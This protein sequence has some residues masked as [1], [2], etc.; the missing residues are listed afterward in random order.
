MNKPLGKFAFSLR[1]N[2]ATSFLFFS[3]ISIS[4][5]V[6]VASQQILSF[7]RKIRKEAKTGEGLR[8]RGSGAG[9]E[10]KEVGEWRRR[11]PN[12]LRKSAIL[13]LAY[14]GLGL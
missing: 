7:C 4:F 14:V 11:T 8:G 1:H 13:H 3:C 6:V 2:T 10:G 5:F 9:A 12:P